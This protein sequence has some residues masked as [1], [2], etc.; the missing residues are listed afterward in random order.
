MEHKNNNK[1]LLNKNILK[2]LK[3]HEKQQKNNKIINKTDLKVL[4]D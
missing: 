2:V 4:A 1:L 3:I